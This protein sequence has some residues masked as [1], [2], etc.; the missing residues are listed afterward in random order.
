[1]VISI[2]KSIYKIFETKMTVTS[3]L[4]K[5]KGYLSTPKNSWIFRY[6]FIQLDSDENFIWNDFLLN[7]TNVSRR[8]LNISLILTKIYLNISRF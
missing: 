7:R 3:E 1:M 8:S 5:S 6:F 4:I 2:S